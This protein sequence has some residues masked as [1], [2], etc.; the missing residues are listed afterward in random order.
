MGCLSSKQIKTS[1]KEYP[2]LSKPQDEIN[3]ASFR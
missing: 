2:S 1:I 3:I